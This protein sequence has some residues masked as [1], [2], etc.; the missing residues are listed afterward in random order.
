MLY[1]LNDNFQENKSGIEHAQLK[2]LKLF[3]HFN[4]PAK[5]VTRQYSNEFAQVMAHAGVAPEDYVNLFDYFQEAVAV[6]SKAV[7]LADLHLNPKWQK[8][9]DGINYNFYQHGQ[10]VMYVRRRDNAQKTIINQQIFDRFGKLV[11]VVWYDVRG[12]KSVEQLYDWNNRITTENYY[13]PTGR[14]ALSKFNFKNQRDQDLVSYHL[15]F[16]G[17]DYH[18]N[19]L[20]ELTSFFYDQIVVDPA[21]NGGQKVGLIVDRV[22]EIGWAVLHM[23][24][25]VFRVMQLH[26]DQVINNDDILHSA[27]NFNYDWGLKNAAAWDG[28]G[29]L[30]PH[31]EADVKARWK[32]SKVYMVPSAI[33]P[34]EVLNAPRV[35]FASRQLHQ[36]VVVAR[37]SPEKQQDHL[38]KVWPKV[39]AAVPDAQLDLW[40]YANDKFDETLKQIVAEEGIEQSVHFRGY[41]E[42]VPE[43]DQKA[44][45]MVLPT[46]GE[47]LAMALVEA[48][49]YGLPV[50]ANDVPYGPSD[51]VVDGHSG[52]LTENGNLDQ[53][54]AKIIELLRDQAKLARFSAGAYEDAHRY[55]EANIMAAYQ[56]IIN[57]L[58]GWQ[59]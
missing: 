47:G 44:Q 29:V 34:D 18:F 11:K 5:I 58:A 35:D 21:I 31:Q 16:R 27:L 17:Q 8:K 15:N 52:Y 46:R 13:T 59:A 53:L 37:L 26:N 33:V 9:A 24:R 3:K 10:R 22:F 20:D 54:A 43:I 19:G 57:D 42:R 7:T 56:T 36:V 2:R 28:I 30:T 55:S 51:I 23:R 49:S 45:L 41:A 38:L 32:E 40:G 14:L 39:L 12:F 25:R 50:I 1:F 6:P 4:Q 48:L